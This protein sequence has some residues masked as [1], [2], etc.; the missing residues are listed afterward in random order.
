MPTL[1]AIGYPDEGT[2]AQAQATA[3]GLE[4]Q[5]ILRAE[6]IASISR[7]F[8][9]N[10]HVRTTY[11]VSPT[12][13]GAVAGGAAGLLVGL[14]L[15]IPVA[16]LAIGAGAGVLLSRF[17]DDEGIDKDFRRQAKDYLQPGTSALLMVIAEVKA[18]EA[19][20]ELR[21]Y[22]GTVIQTSLSDEDERRLQEELQLPTPPAET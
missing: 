10:Y 16:G 8:G 11:G 13:G 14:G 5:K 7:D 15:L 12:T 18:D 1:V 22:G 6:Q 2:A 21:Q 20:A 4:A 17:L 19:I 9:G 3:E